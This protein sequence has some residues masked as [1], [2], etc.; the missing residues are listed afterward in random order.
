MDLH[1]TMQDLD[2][3]SSG[4]SNKYRNSM[5]YGYIPVAFSAT[6]GRHMPALLTYDSALY[7]FCLLHNPIS[8]SDCVIS[9]SA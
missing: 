1:F 9:G 8:V 7:F 5:N 3:T 4:S 6:S 2:V